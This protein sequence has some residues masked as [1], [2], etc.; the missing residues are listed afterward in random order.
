MKERVPAGVFFHKVQYI[1]GCDQ[2]TDLQI[3]T[4]EHTHIFRT[5][6]IHFTVAFF[7]NILDGEILRD[8]GGKMVSAKLVCGQ[9]ISQRP[10]GAV[11]AFGEG[12]IPT[13]GCTANQSKGKNTYDRKRKE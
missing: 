8:P 13:G 4:P 3:A 7:V 1:I 2:C 9:R 6:P 5:N 11:A 10:V 12:E